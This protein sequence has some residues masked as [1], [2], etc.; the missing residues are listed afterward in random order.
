MGLPLYNSFDVSLVKSCISYY[1]FDFSLV[2]S[3]VADLR[4]ACGPH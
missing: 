3:S 4:P 2:V 1:S